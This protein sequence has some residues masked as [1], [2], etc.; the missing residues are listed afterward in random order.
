M[1]GITGIAYIELSGSDPKAPPL[2]VQPGQ[3]YPVIASSP[4]LLFRMDAA[5]NSLTKN[6]QRITNSITTVFNKKNGHLFQNTLENINTASRRLNGAIATTQTTLQQGNVTIQAINDQMLPQ[7][8]S[9]LDNVD[10]VTLRL[11]DFTQQLADNPSILIRGQ[12]PVPLGPGET[13]NTA[14]TRN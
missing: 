11:D 5:I 4:S 1:Q 13:R 12:A 2:T 6:L 8:T 14:K 10:G 9:L 3:Q 7:L